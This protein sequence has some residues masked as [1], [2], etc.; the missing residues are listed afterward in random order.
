MSI[1]GVWRGSLI[2]IVDDFSPA[3]VK[4]HIHEDHV[5]QQNSSFSIS[6]F[7]HQSIATSNLKAQ[8]LSTYLKDWNV[9]DFLEIE[10]NRL[11]TIDN[12][13]LCKFSI[14]LRILLRFT[15]LFWKSLSVNRGRFA[16]AFS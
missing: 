9:V 3:L 2:F 14:A 8:L 7:D 5:L 6:I 16:I 1:G 12:T 11:S 4:V 10:I 13:L 15:Y